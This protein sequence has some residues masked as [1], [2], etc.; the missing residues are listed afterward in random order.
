MAER[1]ILNP[2]STFDD[3][4]N[5]ALHL[6]QDKLGLGLWI[7]T[8]TVGEDWIVLGAAN[9]EPRYDVKQ[10]DVF[11]W[12]DSFCSRMVRGEGPSIAPNSN[13]IPAYVAAP[14]GRKLP[15]GAYV[16]V[17]LQ[18]ADGELFGTLCAI[19][20]KPQPQNLIREEP[21]LQTVGRLVAT[22]LDRDLK[23]QAE[24]RRTEQAEAIAMTDELTGL[25]NRRAWEKMRI[26]EE[27]RCKRHGHRA[28]VLS[29][30]LDGL[31]VANDTGGHN[32]GDDLIKR[33]A[34]ALKAGVR[35]QDVVARV[36]GDE[37][38]ILLVECRQEQGLVVQKRLRHHLA[39]E[40]VSA[41][42][43]FARREPTKNLEE[44]WKCADEAMYQHKRSRKQGAAPRL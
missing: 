43:G 32:A 38:A 16:G 21:L 35:E 10:G 11:T 30:D 25:W 18:T 14:I 17:P 20:P 5:A 13:D 8:R 42:M 9:H 44:A 40:E 1:L 29:I 12:S 26:A 33:A 28:C 22:V 36:G 27:G 15:I 2:F 4:S 34:R 41:S 6:L 39:V 23:L 31:K 37:F 3:A 19:D 24:L 7:I